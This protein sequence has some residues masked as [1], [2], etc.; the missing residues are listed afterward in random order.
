MPPIVWLVEQ[1][2]TLAD[3]ST[4]KVLVPQVY[5]RVREGDID[6][7]GALLSGSSVDMRFAGDLTNASGTIAGRNAVVISAD[8]IHNLGG[9]ITGQDVAVIAQTDLNVIGG[10]IDAANSLSAIAGRDINIVTTTRDSRSST[11]MLPYSDA[12]SGVDLSAVTL[13]RVAG[14]YVTNPG[15]SLMAVAGRDITLAGAEV[16]S[17]GDA[18]LSAGRDMNLDSV[19]TGRSE[20]IRWSEKNAREG[21]QSQEIGSIVSGAGN[22]SLQAGGDLTARAATLSAGETLSLD[23]GDKLTLYAGENQASAETRH[24]TKSGMSH[25]SLDADSQET[26]LARTTLNATDI[27]LRS[28]GDMTL[29][30]IEAN[31]ESLGLQAGGKLSLLTQSTTSAMSQKE[32]EGDA[33]FVS[34]SGSGRVDET[35]NYNRFNVATLNIKADGGIKAQIGERDSLAALG[36]QPGMAWVNQLT[37]DPAFANS[38]EWQRAK[39]EHEK[40]AYSQSGMGPVAA[41]VVVGVATAGAGTAVMGASAA[42]YPAT[43]VA[44]Q[45]GITSMASQA[46]ISLANNN[47]DLS[48]VFKELGSSESIKNIA[49]AMVT[50]GALQGLSSSGILP[51]NLVNATNGSALF[52]DQLQRQLID[53]VASSLVRSAINGTSLE[54]ELQS[55]LATAI[56]NTVAAQGAFAIGTAGPQGN[57]RLNAFTAE[58][59]HAIL[60]CAVGAGRA[61]AGGGSAA[62][63]CSSGAVG[64]VVGN[65]AADFYDP[66]RLLDS[67]S[68][69]GFSQTMAGLAGLLVGGDVSSAYI[70]AAAGGNAVDNNRQLH[71][72]ERTLAHRLSQQSGGRYTPEQIEE[73]MRLMGNKNRGVSANTLEHWDVATQPGYNADP[74]LSVRAV[75]GTTQVIEVAARPDW[76]IQ[77]YIVS[78]TTTGGGTNGVPPWTPYTPSRGGTA[79]INP[80]DAPT[81]RFANGDYNSAAGLG[82]TQPAGSLV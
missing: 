40:W 78:S 31:A 12:A 81:A 35:S 77:Q 36:K 18:S 39:E 43:T 17:A 61:S 3:G 14:L 23:A 66:N 26:T 72:E 25:Y 53:G 32:N 76:E 79:P 56:L 28:G 68:V 11:G 46:T 27:K 30:A 57:Q 75:P 5:V 63:G 22:V 55:G 41:I 16:K 1:E 58:V 21:L 47:G 60:G 45:A 7:S 73:Q 69:S 15:G 38:V 71:P 29:G 48:A 19:T 62:T 52:T 82:N 64:A 50:A 13:D 8:N 2:V 6:G 65:L 24:A 33:A 34:A 10:T 67:A 70:A 51:D 54:D 49:T 42:A 37:S 80:P 4:Q 20:D 9:R 59:A 44:L 74:G